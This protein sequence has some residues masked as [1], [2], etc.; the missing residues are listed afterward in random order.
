MTFVGN[1]G[2]T[3]TPQ[4]LAA[5]YRQ[6]SAELADNMIIANTDASQLV[7]DRRVLK[8]EV[9]PCA[10]NVDGTMGGH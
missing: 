9:S 10:H 3:Y 8:Q 6:G 1:W 5:V 2:E 7:N 4:R